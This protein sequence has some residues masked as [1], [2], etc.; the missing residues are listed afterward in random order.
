M[1]VTYLNLSPSQISLDSTNSNLVLRIPNYAAEQLRHLLTINNGRL[2]F[3]E[4]EAKYEESFGYQDDIDIQKIGKTLVQTASNVVNFAGNRKWLV[5]APS[6]RPYPPHR[7]AHASP[8]TDQLPSAGNSVEWPCFDSVAQATPATE[9]SPVDV[10]HTDNSQLLSVGNSV[11]WPCFDS[12]AQATPTTKHSPVDVSVVTAT[13]TSI[14]NTPISPPTTME[15]PPPLLIC[16]KPIPTPRTFVPVINNDQALSQEE[17]STTALGK[18]SQD[19]TVDISFPSTIGQVSDPTDLPSTVDEFSSFLE[20]AGCDSPVTPPLEVTVD[21]S[22][23]GFLEKELGPEL[24]AEL[25]SNAHSFDDMGTASESQPDL[26]DYLDDDLP[27]PS[28]PSLDDTLE[29][30]ILVSEAMARGE[31]L[32]KF[33]KEEEEKVEQ[34][35]LDDSIE[36]IDYLKTGMNPE[37]VLDEFNKAKERSGGALTPSLMDPFLTYFGELS[38]QAIEQLEAE[39]RKKK[40]KKAPRKRPTMA[41]R[42]PG[43]PPLDTSASQSASAAAVSSDND[44]SSLSSSSLTHNSGSDEGHDDKPSS[45]MTEPETV[46]ESQKPGMGDTSQFLKGNI[47]VGPSSKIASIREKSVSDWRPFLLAAVDYIPN[48]EAVS[49][50]DKESVSE[51]TD[52]VS[53]VD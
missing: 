50:G 45:H 3:N 49:S 2:P 53:D 40:P 33:G 5:W 11:E 19:V 41:I 20:A 47:S 16:N 34:T 24:M 7:R 46:S 25:I 30:L 18:S 15:G 37:Q 35:D 12:V 23:Y 52:S 39:E 43:Q 38:G 42:F 51:S 28:D 22:P 14:V 4:L 31:P 32:P 48:R 26:F 9:Y 21:P 10:S 36:P 8:P 6:G 27:P 17:T 29:K 44:R 13:Q 1:N